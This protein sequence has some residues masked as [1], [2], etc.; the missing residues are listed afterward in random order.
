MCPVISQ[1]LASITEAA[2]S[3]RDYFSSSNKLIAAVQRDEIERTEEEEEEIDH[4]ST[5]G[6]KKNRHSVGAGKEK[7]VFGA[8]NNNFTEGEKKSDDPMLFPLTQNGLRHFLLLSLVQ[9]AW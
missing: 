4:I 2:S 6:R 7:Q 5:R 1:D 8:M 3:S 9:E